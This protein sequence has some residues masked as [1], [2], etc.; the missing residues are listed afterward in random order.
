MGLS[1]A[2]PPLRAAHR[3]PSRAREPLDRELGRAL[4]L[5]AGFLF[6]WIR[7]RRTRT[8]IESRRSHHAR[9][10]PPNL[11]DR[12][13]PRCR[14][15]G[16]L[17]ESRGKPCQVRIFTTNLVRPPSEP[18]LGAVEP[19]EFSGRAAEIPARMVACSLRIADPPVNR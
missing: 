11:P 14:V 13:P 10:R 8:P 9:R 1:W 2:R 18:V 19:H 4:D 15:I 16:S 12:G 7:T 6:V 17:P 5:F 3:A